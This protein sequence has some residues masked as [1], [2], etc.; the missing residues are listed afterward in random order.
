[1]S[2]HPAGPTSTIHRRA[3][4]G[5]TIIPAI[6]T[7]TGMII[8]IADTGTTAVITATMAVRVTAQVDRHIVQVEPIVLGA[9]SGSP[10]R[11]G[12]SSGSS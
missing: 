12:S 11:L 7:I 5:I 6:D 3:T 9:N 1:M 10:K 4:I 8:A 2:I